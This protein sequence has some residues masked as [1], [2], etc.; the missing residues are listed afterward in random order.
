MRRRGPGALGVLVALST[1]VAG[2]KAGAATTTVTYLTTSSVYVGAG[3]RD[4]LV[5]GTRVLAPLEGHVS[6]VLEAVEAS[7][8]RAVC[9]VVEGPADALRVGTS[10]E[11]SPTSLAPATSGSARREARAHSG[12][13]GRGGVRYLLTQDE[14]NPDAGFQQP[15]LDLRL[16][17]PGLF[18][19]AWGFHVDVRTRRTM[20][21]VSG[22][23]IEVDRNRVYQLSVDYDTAGPGWRLALGRQPVPRLANVG[24]L[25]G[26]VAAYDRPRWSAGAFAGT[27]PD[28]E[29]LGYSS[30][31][32]DYG[33]YWDVRSAPG[34][35][36]RWGITT[37][38]V[39]SYAQ[40]EVNRE[41]LFV[42]ARYYGRRLFGTATQEVDFNRG[43]KKETGEST[44]Q[45]TSTYASL[46]YEASDSVALLAWFD[47]RRRVRL[48][49][50]RETP[51]TAFDDEFRRGLWVGADFKAGRHL[52]FGLQGRGYGGGAAGEAKSVG[53][54]VGLVSLT[55]A[56]LS[57]RLRA[58]RYE[59][60]RLDGWLGSGDASIDL[61]SRVRLGVAAG[62]RDDRSR[63]NPLLD[64]S[65]TWFGVDLDVDIGRRLWATVSAER[66]DG[67]FERI[68]QLFVSLAYRF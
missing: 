23:D 53:G 46:R 27:E 8:H 17:G 24:F 43:W 20:G 29:D 62:L 49:R 66:S 33:A 61:A 18:G 31:I 40:S 14:V 39:G 10:V 44:V 59:N 57:L 58:A 52:R 35:G 55:G 36:M 2:G 13:H 67:E 65:V 63:L 45:P 50:D 68:T 48:Y 25:D 19:S 56:D 4:G 47:N 30:A 12:V 3:S 41:Y 54:T 60:D 16:D 15:G 6:V 21:T 64:D 9:R 51:E 26:L 28:I 1:L 42:H 32:R 34:A 22:T 37:G 38:L 11:Y 7:G 5:R